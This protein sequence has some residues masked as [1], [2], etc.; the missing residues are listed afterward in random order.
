MYGIRN[1]YKEEDAAFKDVD[2]LGSFMDNH[3]NARFLSNF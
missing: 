3:D 1:R 2:A